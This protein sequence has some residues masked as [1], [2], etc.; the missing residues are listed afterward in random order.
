VIT[1]NASRRSGALL[2]LAI[3][4]VAPT[5]ALGQADAT[6]SVTP[7]PEPTAAVTEIAPPPRITLRWTTASELDNYGFF[8]MRS[9]VE[10]GPFKPLHPKAIAGA[11]NSEMPHKYS[12]D[13]T[14]VEMGKAYYYYV[15]SVSTR[16]E[17]EKFTPVITKTCCKVPTPTPVEAAPASPVPTGSR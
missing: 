17:R 13:D 3:I 8:V 2:A 15:E 12:Y 4:A 10:E 1:M 14:A 5:A 7:V 11:G 9:D 16:G 6:P